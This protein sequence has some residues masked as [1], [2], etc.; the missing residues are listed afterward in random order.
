MNIN[1]DTF[2]RFDFIV[3]IQS[4]YSEPHAVS[5]LYKGPLCTGTLKTFEMMKG[6]TD[7]LA[8][9]RSDITIQNDTTD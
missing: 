7:A 4:I 5:L 6:K 2:V 3:H 9:R 8:G 1:Y